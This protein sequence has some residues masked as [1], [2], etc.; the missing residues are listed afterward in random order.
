MVQ[1]PCPETCSEL[2]PDKQKKCEQEGY[3]F[4]Y[5]KDA[6]SQIKKEMPTVILCGGVLAEFLYPE[7]RNPLTGK[8]FGRDE[9][10]NMALNPS[11]WGI[12]M[13]R[14]ESQTQWAISRGWIEVGEPYDPKEDMPFYF[15]DMTN[16]KFQ[17]LF[18]SGIKK[19]IDCGVDAIWIDMLYVQPELLKRITGDINHPTVKESYEAASDIID[20]IH[21]YG[22]SKGRYIYV[23]SWAQPIMLEASYPRPDLDA[24][25]TTVGNKEIRAMEMD[26]KKWNVG[27]ERI[28]EKFG[29]IP[30]FARI[31]YGS[32]GSP[33][34]VFSQE[35][36]T[37]QES[38]FLRVADE[39]FQQKGIIFI[40]PIHGGNMAGLKTKSK[41]LSYGK[42]DWYDSLAPEFQTYDTIK[43]LAQNKSKSK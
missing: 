33:L 36:T 39:F 8:T 17:E 12:K 26:E 16:P 41:I 5:L 11:K 10:W 21:Q 19:Q 31:D 23:I 43:E 25:M 28:R 37:E 2:P 30:I 22:L 18:L 32:E 29:D 1:A 40:Y 13:S 9:T 4:E 38:Q 3:S 7:S 14:V 35:L 34:S 15:P 6:T 42:Y 24:L 27:L 20:E